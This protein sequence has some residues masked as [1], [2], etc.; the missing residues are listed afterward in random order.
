MKKIER[1]LIINERVL[2]G[3]VIALIVLELVLWVVIL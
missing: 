1:L 2:I 3:T